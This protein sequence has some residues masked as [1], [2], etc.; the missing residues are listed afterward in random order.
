MTKT[1]QEEIND[2]KKQSQTSVQKAEHLTNLLK[3]Y[4]DLQKYVGR[5]GKEAFCS[6]SVNSKVDDY[7]LRHNCGCCRDSP[8]E[9]WPFLNT[10]HGK[11]YSY[12]AMYM[13]GENSFN[14]DIPYPNWE[15]RLKNNN[16]SEVVIKKLEQYF[17]VQK[18]DD[19]EDVS[20]E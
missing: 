14:G 13:I 5:W 1:L 20:T 2:L 16:I 10:E 18:L 9:V 19:E 15:D 4:P 3:I 17:D 7:D 8:L 6:V 11:I 12:P